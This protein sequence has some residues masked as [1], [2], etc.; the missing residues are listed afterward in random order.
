MKQTIANNFKLLRNKLGLNQQQMANYLEINSREVISYYE[1]GDREIPLEV[2]EK[3]C[4]LFGI[5]LLDIFEEDPEKVKANF[6][7]AYRA[8]SLCD[9]DLNSIGEFK[10]IIKNYQRMKRINETSI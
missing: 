1:N 2:L 9:E 6:H 10:K 3:C 7:L 8:D 4:N 5:E